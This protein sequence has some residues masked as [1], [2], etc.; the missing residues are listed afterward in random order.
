CALLLAVSAL[1]ARATYGAETDSPL[2][3]YI[4]WQQQL[5]CATMNVEAQFQQKDSSKSKIDKRQFWIFVRRDLDRDD[6]ETRAEILNA[7]GR[8]LRGK[9][10][11]ERYIA[12]NNTS[13][14]YRTPNGKR[15]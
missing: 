7:E 3:R 5:R 15:T 6:M 8:P 10:Y 2:Q 13:L 9:R 11:R 1:L 4:Q 12:Q 14:G